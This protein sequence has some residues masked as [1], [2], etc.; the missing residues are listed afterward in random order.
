MWA[1]IEGNSGARQIVASGAVATF[2]TEPV[3]LIYNTGAHHISL[4]FQF[5]DN[6]AE[7]PRFTFSVAPNNAITV[8]FYN[9][10]ASFGSGNI[11]PIALGTYSNK[12]LYLNAYV[13][14][15]DQSLWRTVI[16]SLFL[17]D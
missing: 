4:T 10:N 12:S 6:P 11:E 17:G 16:Y 2:A 7:L 5:I 3:T 9:A 8:T 15:L 1:L 14:K 13:E